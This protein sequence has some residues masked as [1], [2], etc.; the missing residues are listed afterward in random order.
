MQKISDLQLIDYS[1]GGFKCMNNFS[2]IIANNKNDKKSQQ[3]FKT[4]P[5]VLN[6]FS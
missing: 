5:S 2:S 1:S 4:D 3:L 6:D